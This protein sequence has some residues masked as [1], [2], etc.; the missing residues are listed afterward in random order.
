M[1]RFRTDVF[2]PERAHGP[3]HV[4]IVMLNTAGA[5]TKNTA[6]FRGDTVGDAIDAANTLGV[7]VIAADRPFSGVR[8]PNPFNAL[9]R[10]T[11]HEYEKLQREIDFIVSG[12]G[13]KRIIVTGRSVAGFGA[14][15]LGK[16]GPSEVVA[17]E[18]G[19]MYNQKIL[20]GY[21]QYQRYNAAEH[22]ALK[23][24]TLDLDIRPEPS[25]QT[26]LAGVRRVATFLI[27]NVVDTAN[28]SR[29]L[30]TN[31]GAENARFIASNL[32]QTRLS[33]IYAE[34][35]LVAPDLDPVVLQSSL[36][37]LRDAADGAVKE[38]IIVEQVPNT[39]HISFN[40]RGFI[41]KVLAKSVEYQADQPQN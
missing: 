40:N 31:R 29:I 13:L 33:L 2:T 34:D 30:A 35:S 41:A 1:K 10:D 20:Q 22:K 24:G 15:E 18:P 9:N 21:M 38:D 14:L 28:Y 11:T 37:S 5:T 8:M 7:T 25:D 3:D 27:G 17:F 32:P 4:G 19:A 36:E 12:I 16:F 23:D 39:S 6:L 26:G